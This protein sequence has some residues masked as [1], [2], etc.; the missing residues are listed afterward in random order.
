MLLPENRVFVCSQSVIGNEATRVSRPGDNAYAKRTS[1]HSLVSSIA[2]KV[3]PRAD[4]GC[5]GDK[6]QNIRSPQSKAVSKFQRCLGV[7]VFRQ[8]G[9]CHGPLSLPLSSKNEADCVS[10]PMDRLPTGWKN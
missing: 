5:H 1:K 7:M 2:T 10:I 3:N 8:D 9:L 4:H 6:D